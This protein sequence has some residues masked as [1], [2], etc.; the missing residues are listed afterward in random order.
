[1]FTQNNVAA[2]TTNYSTC[3]ISGNK[4][5]ICPTSRYLYGQSQS[6]TSW[7][8]SNLNNTERKKYNDVWVKT[9]EEKGERDGQGKSN[10]S[11]NP[12]PKK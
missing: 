3:L 5:H 9:S 4:G 8:S 11:E 7:S 1:M 2:P 12:K 6:D 10:W